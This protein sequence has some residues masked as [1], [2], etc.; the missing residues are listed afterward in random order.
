MHFLLYLFTEKFTRLLFFIIYPAD[1]NIRWSSCQ[2]WSFWAGWRVFGRISNSGFARTSWSAEPGAFGDQ[3][4]RKRDSKKER[5]RFLLG[6]WVHWDQWQ[7]TT[8]CNLWQSVAK[9]FDVPSKNAS[10]F[11]GGSIQRRVGNN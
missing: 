1:T 11:W 9:Q 10:S 6:Y 2:C 3:H 7:Q 5:P 8:V 4:H